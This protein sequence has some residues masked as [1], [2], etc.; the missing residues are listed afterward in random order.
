MF[1]YYSK[2]KEVLQKYFLSH[3]IFIKLEFDPILEY[4]I[5]S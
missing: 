5:E 2:S 1:N 4:F 3:I